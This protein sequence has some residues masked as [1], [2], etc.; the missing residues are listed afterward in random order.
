MF[1]V[2]DLPG[3]HTYTL[4]Q[5]EGPGS[6]PT[7]IVPSF[8]EEGASHFA[9]CRKLF[10]LDRHVLIF[11]A[12]V[13]LLWLI[14][15]WFV[16]VRSAAPAGHLPAF[17]GALFLWATFFIIGGLAAL[18]FDK[19]FVIFHAVLFPGKTNWLFDPRVDQVIN[20]L[21]ET[22][23][24]HCGLLIVLLILCMSAAIFLFDLLWRK[25]K[26]KRA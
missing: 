26:E 6:F 11:T 2:A 1:L 4:T 7:R 19:F 22:Y 14:I 23:F 9:D 8:S 20:I 13:A 10:V 3:A 21:P 12:A 18:D 17:Y 24:M 5:P 25:R 16:P 15:R